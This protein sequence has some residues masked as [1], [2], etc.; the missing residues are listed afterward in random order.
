MDYKKQKTDYEVGY[1]K[2]PKS[3]QFQKGI[4]GN[5][6]GRPKKAS[7]IGSR[8]IQE[9]NS[10]LIINENGKR[11]VVKKQDGVTKQLVNKALSGNLQATRLVIAL[12]QQALE[13]AAEQQRNSLYNRSRPASDLSDEELA[14]IIR[15][16]H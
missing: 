1:K 2:P 4:T 14:A 12:Y 5:P 6:K 8:L 7:D 11:K 16:E 10:D 15:G 3:G 9:L 13:S